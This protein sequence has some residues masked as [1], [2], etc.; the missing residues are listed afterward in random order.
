[1]IDSSTARSEA[2]TSAIEG[3]AALT[4]LIPIMIFLILICLIVVVFLFITML[5]RLDVIVDRLEDQTAT[6]DDKTLEKIEELDKSRQQKIVVSVGVLIGFAVAGTG[7]YLNTVDAGIAGVV[8]MAAGVVITLVSLVAPLIQSR[9][10]AHEDIDNDQ[11]THNPTARHAI[12]SEE[13][14]LKKSSG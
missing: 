6:Y 8:I 12:A 3:Y 2:W 13:N 4:I 5:G 9:S 14:S 7:I 11:S 1:M 10:G